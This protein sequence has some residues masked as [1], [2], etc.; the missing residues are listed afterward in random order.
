MNHEA[1][2]KHVLIIEDDVDIRESIAELLKDV[3][4]VPHLAENGAEGLRALQSGLNPD[5][6][7][8]DLMMPVMD[9]NEFRAEQQK[10][11]EWSHIPVIVMSANGHLL[12][13]NIALKANEYLK[14]PLDIGYLLEV[15]E[16]VTQ[17]TKL[18]SLK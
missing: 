13:N 2:Q 16:K 11:S 7:L 4:F 1:I 12:K 9:G 10:N 17:Q 6:I 14:K 15:I 5:L 3:G 8:L 18:F